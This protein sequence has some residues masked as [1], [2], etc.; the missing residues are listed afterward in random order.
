MKSFNF[1]KTIMRNDFTIIF[2]RGAG[3]RRGILSYM[4]KFK[5]APVIKKTKLQKTRRANQGWRN[6]VFGTIHALKIRLR[7]GRRKPVAQFR[8]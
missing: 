5:Q 4:P 6:R 3:K 7:Y 2:N 1:R 8:R